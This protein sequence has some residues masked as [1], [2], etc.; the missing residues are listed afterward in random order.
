EPAITALTRV[1]DALWWAE[2][3]DPYAVSSRWETG[4]GS[5]L[6]QGRRVKMP[7]GRPPQPRAV[8]LLL[9][10]IAFLAILR[11]PYRPHVILDVPPGRVARAQGRIFEAQAAIDRDVDAGEEACLVGGEKDRRCGEIR[12]ARKPAERDA[13]EKVV[14]R[15]VRPVG[16][17][18]EL[19]V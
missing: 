3:R 15:I 10:R 12:G 13:L 1:L 17:E 18:H 9:N 8:S 2:S 19:L 5:L 4:Y 7:T 6:S 14:A 16:L 11:A